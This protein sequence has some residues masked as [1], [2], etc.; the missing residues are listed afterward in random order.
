MKNL[1][2]IE[3]ILHSVELADEHGDKLKN[4]QRNHDYVLSQL[5]LELKEKFIFHYM[6]YKEATALPESCKRPKRSNIM[7]TEAPDSFIQKIVTLYE[8]NKEF[9]N[10]L[11]LCIMKAFF[12]NQCG[13]INSAFNV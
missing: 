1:R 5:G 10:S 8:Q 12:A 11:I 13:N 2:E 7:F 3:I 9:R 4:F 6:F